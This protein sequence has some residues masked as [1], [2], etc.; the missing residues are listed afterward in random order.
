MKN[1]RSSTPRTFTAPADGVVAGRPV[2]LGATVVIP[3]DAADEGEEFVGVVE[4]VVE[5]DKH[6]AAEAFG[7]TAGDDVYWD[8]AELECTTVPTG[9]RVGKASTDV[10]STA[11]TLEVVLPGVAVR[12]LLDAKVLACHDNDAAATDGRALFV[13]QTPTG[14][15]FA[16]NTEGAAH[17]AVTLTGGDGDTV[18]VLHNADPAANLAGRQVYFDEDADPQDRLLFVS[19]HSRDAWVTT[20]GGRLVRVKHDAAAATK[21]VAL[22]LDDADDHIEFV[23]PTN[24]SGSAYTSTTRLAHAVEFGAGG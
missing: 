18:M 9:Y 14:T 8:P 7:F 24:T 13:C 3:Q 19:V 15:V 2:W 16:N 10:A 22:Y 4:G 17:I 12:S 11:A 5:L 21:G 6:A 23:S 1:Y 20:L